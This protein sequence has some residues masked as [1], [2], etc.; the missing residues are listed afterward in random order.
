VRRRAH[1]LGVELSDLA[2][3]SGPDGIVTL[4]DVEAAARSSVA[5]APTAPASAGG[6]PAAA[7]G[8]EVVPV[9][10]VRARIAERMTTSAAIPTASASVVVDC[11]RLLEVRARLDDHAER[12][13]RPR[14]ITPF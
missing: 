8:D 11:T 3:G 4:A 5:P 1:E 13:G 7:P 6:E 14:V 2:P 10:G 12:L 9:R